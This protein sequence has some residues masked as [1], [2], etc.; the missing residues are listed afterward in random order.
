MPTEETLHA[1]RAAT[2]QHIRE[3]E[4]VGK[5]GTRY[6]ARI[7][8]VWFLV[9]GLVSDLGWAFQLVEGIQY[10]RGRF[11]VFPL[12]DLVLLV[13]GIAYTVRL[14]L[15]HEKEIALRHQKNLSFGLVGLSGL[16]AFA[17]GSYIGAAG[18]SI[19]GILNAAGSLGIYFSFKKGIRYGIK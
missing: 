15:I 8:D 4:A 10:L 3:L 18:F 16:L 19:G 17:V 14:D 5:A 13:V 11:D 2:E 9:L 12:I 6:T 7:P 1:K